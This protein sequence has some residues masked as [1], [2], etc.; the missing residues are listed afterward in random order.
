MYYFDKDKIKNI[1]IFMTDKHM[2][3]FVVS[4]P[5]IISVVNYFN[6]K[7]K[8]IVIDESYKDI[9]L[10]FFKQEKVV[11]YNLRKSRSK[12]GSVLSFLILLKKLKSVKPSL[13]IDF[14]G[15][16]GG[17]F[18]SLLS[19][20]K[21]KVGFKGGEKSYCYNIKISPNGYIHKSEFYLSIPQ[22]LGIPLIK[23]LH[24][25]IREEWYNS[26]VAKLNKAGII[27][28]N[29]IVCI[30]PGAG[31][32]YKKWPPQNFASLSDYLIDK[33]YSVILIGSHR[34]MED[35]SQI[36]SYM[37]NKAY[38]FCNKLSLG[39]LMA[40]FKNSKLYIGNDSGPMHLAAL[41]DVPI[42]AL[43]GSADEKRWKPLG[44]KVN[45]L[46]SSERC[47]KCRG[48]DCEKDFRCIT[49]IS[50]EEVINKIGLN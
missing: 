49:S 19:G 21:Y 47:E 26:L 20:A 31:K 43:F 5:A 35:I 10:A 11:L 40:L 32:I 38:D 36:K 2:G 42:I 48:K 46:K 50:T 29:N 8:G 44:E 28:F 27:D 33:G 17:A 23:E 30:H 37:K 13:S 7:V 4:L 3:N 34:D 1:L 14:E 9:A 22:N 12:F 25:K 39:E 18:L 16:T 24:P 45:V 6:E 15:R 41:F